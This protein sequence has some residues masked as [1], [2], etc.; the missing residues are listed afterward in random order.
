MNLELNAIASELVED[1]IEDAESLRV[2][3]HDTPSEGSCACLDL[4]G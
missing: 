1:V 4:Q 2:I 3:E